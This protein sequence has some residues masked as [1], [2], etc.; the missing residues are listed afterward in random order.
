MRGYE[1]TPKAQRQ[2]DEQ[3]KLQ[4]D[5]LA[6][7]ALVVSEWTTDPTSV[8]CFD[9]RLVQRAKEIHARLKQLDPFYQ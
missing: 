1:L 2:L 6:I 5:A 8:Q 9:L 3:F 7:F 4:H